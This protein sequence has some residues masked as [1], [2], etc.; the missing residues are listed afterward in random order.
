M[1]DVVKIARRI[2]YGLAA[3]KSSVTGVEGDLYLETDTGKLDYWNSDISDW[4]DVRRQRIRCFGR[5]ITDFGVIAP[6]AWT[7]FSSPIFRG[8]DLEGIPTN[9]KIYLSTTGPGTVTVRLQ[10]IT[11]AATICSSAGLS[12]ARALYDLGAL[13]NIPAA[14]AEMELQVLPSGGGITVEIGGI[15]LYYP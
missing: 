15:N 12:G 8:F 6:V 13:A 3:D 14:E 4:D 7:R 1:V 10:D 11:N 9:C 5:G 2:Y